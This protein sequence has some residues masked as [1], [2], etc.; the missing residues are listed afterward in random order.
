MQ[1][2]KKRKHVSVRAD[3]PPQGAKLGGQAMQL[4]K[5][6]NLKTLGELVP[7]ML[8]VYGGTSWGK[9]GTRSVLSFQGGGAFVCELKGNL[10]SYTFR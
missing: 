5:A 6:L 2:E 9:G 8:P 3:P 10:C 7:P 4:D 1:N